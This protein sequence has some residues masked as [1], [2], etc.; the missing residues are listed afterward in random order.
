MIKLGRAARLWNGTSLR[1]H[2]W[3]NG[4]RFQNKN[5]KWLANKRCEQAYRWGFK[6]FICEMSPRE[7]KS[8]LI[9]K[10]LN[11]LISVKLLILEA[12]VISYCRRFLRDRS[13]FMGRG[14]RSNL[15]GLFQKNGL[16]MW[17]EVMPKI[18]MFKGGS[19]SICGKFRG[20]YRSTADLH[21]HLPPLLRFSKILYTQSLTMHNCIAVV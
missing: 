8:T 14:G 1:G 10:G 17:G 2:K 4:A 11:Y 15:G 18:C 12:I 21:D 20:N 9:D 13:F 19:P 16:Q 6:P 7:Y 3:R 5:P